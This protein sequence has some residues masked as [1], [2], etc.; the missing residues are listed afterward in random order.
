LRFRNFRINN[1][2]AVEMKKLTVGII[3]CGRIGSL[4][5][6]DPLRGK[7]CT[8]AG[9]FDS[10]ASVKLVAGCD[11][12]PSRLQQFGRRWGVDRLYTD[13]REML[14]QENLDIVCIAT[15]TP[16]HGSMV[17]E[18]ARSGVKGIYCEKPLSVDLTEA[19]KMVKVCEKKGIPLIINHERRWDFYYQKA[20]D[21]IRSGK[22]GE[23]KTIIGNALSWKPSKLRRDL[24]GGGALFHDGTHLTDLLIYFGGTIDWVS[25]HEVRTHGKK[26]IEETASAMIRFKSGAIGFIEGGGARKYFNF[27]L[28][29]Q[30]SEG[31]ILIGNDGRKLYLTRKS[32][33]FT[34]FQ[35][36]QPAVFP[37]PKNLQSPFT[38]GAKDV[39]RCIRTGKDSISSGRDGLNALEVIFAIYQSAQLKGKRIKIR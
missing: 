2:V 19:R 25:G 28:D 8:H 10:L 38:G 1:P 22:I 23:I 34:G 20:R 32:K 36:L 9:G 14:R 30:G 18:A 35:E 39:V 33:R 24:H 6:E 7:P 11:I 27:E 15:W 12:D 37:E 26:Y 29:I 31:R 13:Y 21:I 4:L 16:L 17:I 3:G 5:E